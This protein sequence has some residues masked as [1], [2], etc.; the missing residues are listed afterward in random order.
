MGKFPRSLP[1]LSRTTP[2]DG[3]R[4]R[5]PCVKVPKNRLHK[6]C[7][8]IGARVCPPAF[9]CDLNNESDSYSRRNSFLGLSGRNTRTVLHNPF[10]PD[11][12]IF[13]ALAL[14]IQTP[15]YWFFKTSSKDCASTPDTLFVGTPIVPLCPDNGRTLAFRGLWL[16]PPLRICFAAHYRSP[17]LTP[18]TDCELS[19]QL[20]HRR[21]HR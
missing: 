17:E 16:P 21:L 10:N 5:C 14:R 7:G 20:P 13:G 3:D 18:Q 6:L 12:P 4:T 19:L 11:S 9:L 2:R 1:A 8:T 15:A